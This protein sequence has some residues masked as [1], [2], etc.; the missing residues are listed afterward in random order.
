MSARGHSVYEFNSTAVE[1]KYMKKL[2]NMDKEKLP[3][4]GKLPF[5]V[6]CVSVGILILLSFRVL[7]VPSSDLIVSLG[8]G[9][10]SIVLGLGSLVSWL[11]DQ[12]KRR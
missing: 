1:Q 11:V 6:A 2:K 10:F 9:G 4:E 5:S 3:M 12:V 7:T 8:W